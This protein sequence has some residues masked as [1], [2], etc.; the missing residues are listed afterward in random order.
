LRASRAAV[1][2]FPGWNAMLRKKGAT[3]ASKQDA[4]AP[5]RRAAQR[6]LFVFMGNLRRLKGG[7]W[8]LR[9]PPLSTQSYDK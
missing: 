2:P 4:Q 1:S 7:R 8:R 6:A 5:T 3:S 9:P